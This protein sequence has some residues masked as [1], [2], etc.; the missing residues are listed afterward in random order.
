MNALLLAVFFTAAPRAE[1]PAW[2]DD[3]AAA[4][5]A[6]AKTGRP[7]LV[8]FH[9][10]WCYSCYYMESNVLSKPAFARAAAGMIR[11]KAD[12]DGAPG[13]DLKRRHAVAALPTFLVLDPG[14][15]EL[16]RIAGEQSEPDFLARLAAIRRA[17]Q[18]PLERDAAALRDK[19]SAGRAAEAAALVSRL[20]AARLKGL[21][22]RKDWRVLEARLALARAQGP[23][24]AAAL[25]A[26]LGADDSCELVYDVLRAEPAVD[27][28]EASRRARL[29]D[30]ERAALESL[31][32]RRLFTPN[33]QRCADFRSGIRA[34][35]GVYEKLGQTEP[36]AYL[37]RRTLLFLERMGLKTGQD[38]NHDDDVRFFLEAAGED[39][40]LR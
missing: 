33:A 19:L 32:A 8:E 29:L 39:A 14:G 12:V 2:L 28:L 6:A 21:R 31:A 26:L 9:A 4:Q 34:L 1:V 27:A 15:K 25:E 30:A 38:R 10:P 13:R 20:S 3:P 5:A 22:A 11:L 17:G 18:D 24:A 40:R 36:R 7:L 37:L 23:A 16:G 35:A